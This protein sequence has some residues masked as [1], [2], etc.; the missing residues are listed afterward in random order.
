[1][2][3]YYQAGNYVRASYMA[4]DL[5]AIDPI[6]EK[7]IAILI[8]SYRKLNKNAEAIMAYQEFVKE[9]QR[10]YDDKYP[11]AYRNI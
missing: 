9:Y 11:V 8:N 10:T 6:H 1:M 3:E 2:P 5:L 7:A 4:I